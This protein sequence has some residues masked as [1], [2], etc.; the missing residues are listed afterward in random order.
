MDF[1]IFFLPKIWLKFRITWEGTWTVTASCISHAEVQDLLF[2]QECLSVY[3]SPRV[4]V[5]V[6]ER[7]RERE[8]ERV[9]ELVG[10]RPHVPPALYAH[11][12]A[13]P[14]P[15]FLSCSHSSVEDGS[16]AR[17]S[18]QV[19][20]ALGAMACP[21]WAPGIWT[22]DLP[23]DCCF[24]GSWVSWSSKTW[25]AAKPHCFQCLCSPGLDWLR[26]AQVR[27]QNERGF[28]ALNYYFQLNVFV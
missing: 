7:E 4:C 9:C 21:A 1:I 23:T 11:T 22:W 6:C 16:S 8:R 19:C 20:G 25:A 18:V 12:P 10:E 5:C 15:D 17:L 3:V 26:E 27:C 24:Q 2:D 14:L 28:E 13:P